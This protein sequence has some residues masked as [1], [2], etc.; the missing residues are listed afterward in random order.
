MAVEA[1]LDSQADLYR[2]TLFVEKGELFDVG[3]TLFAVTLASECFF[4]TALLAGLEVKGVTF[5]L[6]ND[7]FLLNL[8]LESAESA[9]QRFAVLQYYFCQTNSPP[10]GTNNF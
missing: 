9:F 2:P 10:P 8:A 6:F 5:D 3:T 1:G 4:G 7:V